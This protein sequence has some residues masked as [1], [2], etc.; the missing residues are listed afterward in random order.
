MAHMRLLLPARMVQNFPQ[1]LC[2]VPGF[3]R[4]VNSSH[5]L[6]H[7]LNPGPIRAHYPEDPR[8][9]LRAMS[10]GTPP[11]GPLWSPHGHWSDSGGSPG[12]R[13]HSSGP[14][15]LGTALSPWVAYG[16][17]PQQFHKDVTIHREGTHEV[18]Q[19]D[20]TS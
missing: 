8:G 7:D 10:D 18:A 15:L 1:I 2:L 9:E 4:A 11:P 14:P 6:S 19:T 3:P 20:A 12:L 5:H 16:R 17:Q 13:Y